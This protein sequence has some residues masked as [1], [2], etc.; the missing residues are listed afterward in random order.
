M[1]GTVGPT[2]WW[3]R[4]KEATDYYA[5]ICPAGTTLPDG[6]LIYRRAGGQSWIVAPMC[7]QAGQQWAGGS[8][9]NV[10]A[11]DAG[12]FICCVCEWSGS[13]SLCSCL[14]ANGFNPCEWFVP[15]NDILLIAY[16]SAVAGCWG[17]PSPTCYS[18]PCYWSS[19]EGDSTKAFGRFF[20]NGVQALDN[21]SVPSCVRAIRC[22]NL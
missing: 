11:T 5:R 14:I 17:G 9:N 12:K 16:N 22:I 20:T 10:S 13:N 18:V 21:K 8:Y 1:S 3:L 6:S 4:T 15:D 7:T 19:S 2:S